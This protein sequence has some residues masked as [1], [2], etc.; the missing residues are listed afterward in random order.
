MVT[1]DRRYAPNHVLV[2]VD[3][4]GLADH[5]IR[6]GLEVANRLGARIELLHAAGSA[7][8]NWDAFDDARAVSNEEDSTT[9]AWKAMSAHITPILKAIT[10][11]AKVEDVVR[12]VHG[13][14]A[15]V[16]L[17]RARELDADVIFLGS[18]RH[19]GVLDFGSTVRAVLARAPKAVWV[20]TTPWERIRTILVPIDLSPDSLRA[21]SH[22]CALANVFGARVHAVNVFQTGG[23]MMATWPDYPDYGKGYVIADVRRKQLGE[24]ESA[25]AAFDWMGAPHDAE[26]VDGEPVEKVLELSSACDLIVLGT[27][28]RTGLSAVLLGNVAYSVLKRA[29]KPVLAIRHPEREFV[30]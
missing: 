23:Y 5:A 29:A 17:D 22:A 14:P 12:V 18:H 3:A 7:L 26:F 20:Q 30:T 6:A 27:H 1:P 9:K 2:A 28:G 11:Q 24:F 13:P 16:I 4:E 19:K 15:K 25:L 21:L 8:R 10:A